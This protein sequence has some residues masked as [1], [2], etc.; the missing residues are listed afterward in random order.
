MQLR[1]RI[2]DSLQFQQLWLSS[3]TG[4]G[5]LV[6]LCSKNRLTAKLKTNQS[7]FKHIRMLDL[8]ESFSCV[9]T[10]AESIPHSGDLV[11]TRKV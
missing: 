1:A 9:V 6:R 3:T 8:T 11:L 7:S 4:G 5:G 2:Y 10:L